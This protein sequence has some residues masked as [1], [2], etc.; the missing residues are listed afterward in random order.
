MSQLADIE[1]IVAKQ[2]MPE[3]LRARLFLELL[4]ALGWEVDGVQTAE[5]AEVYLFGMKQLG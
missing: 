1:D 5:D 3:P 2:P 4:E